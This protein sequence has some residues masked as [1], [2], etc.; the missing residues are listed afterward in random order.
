MYQVAVE[1]AFDFSSPE[2]AAL[3]ESS[4]ATA[5][6]HPIWLGTLYG[7]LL[8]YNNATPL[9]VVVRRTDDRSLAMV[10]PLIKRRYGLLKVVEFADLR[11]S[12]YSAVVA[13]RRNFLAV[14]DEGSLQ[15]RLRHLLEP[16]DVLRIGKLGDD[17][18][19]MNRLFG[20]PAP[21]RMS[22]NAYAVP[23]TGDF[24]TWRTKY[25]NRSYAKELGKKMRQLERKGEVRFERVTAAETLRETF[26]AM[27]LFRRDR[28]EVNGGGELLQV[29]AYFEFY[30]QVAARPELART[31]RLTLDGKTIA[32]ALGLSHKGTLLVILGG[33]TQ[34]EHKNQSVGSLMFELIAKDCIAQGDTVLDFTIGDEPYKLTFGATPS[35]MW[36]MSRAGSALGLAASTVIEQLPSARALARSLFH[37]RGGPTPKGGPGGGTPVAATAK[38]SSDE[39]ASA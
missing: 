16:Y 15:R 25:L 26:E 39:P 35:P 2:Y 19:R 38:I 11:V 17:A 21:R 14:L 30:L 34:T 33:F 29:P 24:E 9:V 27:R 23:L 4:S 31:Y 1:N 6:Q 18:L 10:L 28:F 20:I 13:D 12:D 36:Q 22:T 37:H 8:A 32:S 5:F 3:Y 7:R